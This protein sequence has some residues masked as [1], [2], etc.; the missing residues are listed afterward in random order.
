[1]N[2]TDHERKEK[3][4]QTQETKNKFSDNSSKL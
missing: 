2:N 3:S 1:M 4:L